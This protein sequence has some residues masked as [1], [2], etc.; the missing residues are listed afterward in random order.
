MTFASNFSE[1]LSAFSRHRVEFMLTGGYAVN[2][3]GYN[4]STSDIDLWIKPVETNKP[5]LIK[6][7]KYL[8]FS[9]E[10]IDEVRA[11]DFCKPFSFKIGSDPVDI[12]IF[13]HITGVS[14]SEADK[15]KVPF[16]DSDL[17]LT[18]YFISLRDLISNKMLTGRTIDK[19]DVEQLQKISSLRK[20]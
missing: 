18:V 19:L 6:A 9:K 7:I 5:R 14:Y 11:L 1:I 4:R 2:F 20:K 12:D 3:H 13:N 15:N 10:S 16:V 17:N 8:G